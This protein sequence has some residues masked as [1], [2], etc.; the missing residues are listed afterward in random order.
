MS[1][2]TLHQDNRLTVI[3]GI[4]HALGT[5]FQ[6]FDKDLENET[7]DGEG[8]VL[9]WSELFGFETN[10]TGIPNDTGVLK[11]L[12]MYVEEHGEENSNFEPLK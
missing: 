4:D 9:D 12:I 6:I 3:T 11:I 8:I 10:L 1:R 7:P 2:E 5:F